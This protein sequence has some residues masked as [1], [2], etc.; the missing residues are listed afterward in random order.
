MPTTT[1]L[2]VI[3]KIKTIF[4]RGGIPEKVV[5]DNCPQ[6]SAQ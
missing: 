2:A 1:S 6:F 5:S 3:N 4:V